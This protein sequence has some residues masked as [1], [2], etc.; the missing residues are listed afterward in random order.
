MFF[1]SLSSDKTFKK[2]VK[3]VKKCKKK[4][5]FYTVEKP[6]ALHIYSLCLHFKIK[7]KITF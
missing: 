5:D 1:T 4:F 2:S 6:L 7:R 3:N